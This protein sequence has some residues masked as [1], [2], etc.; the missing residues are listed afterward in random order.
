MTTW[1]GTSWKMT[2]TLSEA[3]DFAQGLAARSRETAWPGVQ[4]FVIPSFTA[5]RLVA[6]VLD[7]TDVLVGAQNAHWED[8]GAWTGEVSARQVADAGAVLV[9]IGH[10]E[11]RAHFA[12]T[13]E[14]VALKV[15]ATLRHGLTPLVCVGEPEQ[16]LREGRS[17]DFVTAQV[18]AALS[19]A[20]RV[21]QDT[22][23][24]AYE[25]VW[26]IGEQGRPA[27][28]DEIAPVFEV[29]QARLGDRVSRFLYGGSVAQDNVARNLQIPH[30]G[31][32]FVGRSAW[33]LP[34]F[35]RILDTAASSRS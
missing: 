16:V 17:A 2:K 19:G 24:V 32:L 23:V 9:E 4:P 33:A 27:Q 3:A 13:D 28:P 21:A 15:A 5:L 25:P 31:G 35:L 7:G 1:V 29:L 12:E 10:S 20:P 6:D 11:R 14:T 34:G 30:V 26:A 22:V 18:E 8:E